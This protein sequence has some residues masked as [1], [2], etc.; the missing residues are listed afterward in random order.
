MAIGHCQR[1]G[2]LALSSHYWGDKSRPWTPLHPNQLPAPR[3]KP[4]LLRA[5]PTLFI[6]VLCCCSGSELAAAATIAPAVETNV[7]YQFKCLR[8]AFLKKQLYT[9][10]SIKKKQCYPV[11]IW[12]LKLKNCQKWH[13]GNYFLLLRTAGQRAAATVIMTDETPVN[14][15]QIFCIKPPMSCV[16]QSQCTASLQRGRLILNQCLVPPFLLWSPSVLLRLNLI[17]S[18]P[19]SFMM[20]HLVRLLKW[21]WTG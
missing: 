7:L 12:C 16:S 19:P 20:D 6:S 4:R 18:P 8:L 13:I 15:C 14:F 3:D 17:Q 10:T 11:T 1:P 9:L 2:S 21:E 5:N